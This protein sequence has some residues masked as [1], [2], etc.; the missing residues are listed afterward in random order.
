MM[1]QFGPSGAHGKQVRQIGNGALLVLVLL[2]AY[3]FVQVISGLR[4]YSYIGGG[5][6]ATNTISVSGTGDVYVTPDIAM[7]SFSVVEEDKTVAAA[8][9]TATEKMNTILGLIRGAGVED[10]DIQTTGYN[11]YPQYDYVQEACTALRCPPGKQVLR[12]YQVSQTITIKVRD[13]GKAGDL[14]SKI[15]SAGASNVS[16]LTFTVDDDNAPKEDARKKAIEDAQKKAATLS[17]DLG[18]HIVRVVSFSENG[19]AIPYY[20]KT[21][22][23][24][25][26]VGMGGAES[27]PAPE[28]PVGENHVVSNVTITYEIR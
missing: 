10:K 28:I 2:A 8:Q 16:G 26:A 17:K 15:G 1:E 24:D 25:S 9:K 19:N 5:V 12:G 14:L 11:I 27:A 3:L 7:F 20:A 22:T 23:L 13:I 6:P 18:V 4:S 21:M